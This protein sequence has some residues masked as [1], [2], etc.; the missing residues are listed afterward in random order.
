V[1]IPDE[2]LEAPA[3][4]NCVADTGAT[5]QQQLQHLF[6]A[7]LARRQSYSSCV[8]DRLINNAPHQL[9]HAVLGQ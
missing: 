8:L 7:P 6:P 1:C 9:F 3:V 2:Y 4:R 5:S